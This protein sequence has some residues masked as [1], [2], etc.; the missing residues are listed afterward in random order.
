M[1]DVLIVG[2]GPAGLTAAIYACRAGWRT[3]LIEAGAFGGQA[4]TTDWIENYPGFAAGISGPDLMAEFY[5]QAERLGCS[6]LLTEVKSLIK[7]GNLI[8][9]VS[10]EKEVV[11]KV[12][13]IATGARPRELGVKGEKEFHGKGV[14][15]CATC[16]GFFYR[17]KKV[18]VV[19]GGNAAV[20]EALFLSKIA[21]EIVLLHRRDQLR[22]DQ[23][24][25]EQVQK[26][27]KINI[28]WSTVLEEIKGSDKIEVVRLRNLKSGKEEEMAIEGVFI[29]VGME[30]VTEFLGNEFKKTQGYLVTDQFLRTNLPGIFAIGDCREKEARQIATAVGD[31]ASVMVGVEAYLQDALFLGGN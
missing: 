7:D 4:T 30:P 27:E 24:L 18:V 21:R 1:Y 14:S 3:L 28:R 20:K 15:Y 19:G 2:G 29:Y 5:Q 13:I 31:G 9:L 25:A 12:A 26:T 17:D 6:F 22:A 10:E 8:K 11:G 16:D 23:I